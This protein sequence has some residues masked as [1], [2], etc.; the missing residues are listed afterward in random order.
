MLGIRR[1]NN[2]KINKDRSTAFTTGLVPNGVVYNRSSVEHNAALLQ[3]GGFVE[4]DKCI[5]YMAK[6]KGTK[7]SHADAELRKLDTWMSP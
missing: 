7:N 4:Y 6:S 3:M 2:Y 5:P 1:N